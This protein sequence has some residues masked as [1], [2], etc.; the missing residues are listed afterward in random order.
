MFC[1]SPII[2]PPVSSSFKLK[3]LVFPAQN[4]RNLIL[5]EIDKNTV[6]LITGGTGCGKT[7]Q[8]PQFLLEEANA[9]GQ[10]VRIMCTQPRRL[11]AIEVAKRVAKERNEP[12]GHT[13]GYHIRLE[14]KLDFFILPFKIFK[15]QKKFRTSSNTALTYCTSGV[16]LR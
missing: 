3:R 5:K 8:I 10:K 7:T 9:K 12:L 13:V 16:L 2:P 15:I 6:T 4:Q 14:Q 11:P 1:V